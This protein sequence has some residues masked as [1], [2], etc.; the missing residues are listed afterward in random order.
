MTEFH[1]IAENHLSK[2]VLVLVF[3]DNREFDEAHMIDELKSLVEAAG[4]QVAGVITQNKKSV[5]A[6]T[7]IGSGKVDEVRALVEAEGAELVVF[8]DELS[9]SQMRNLEER[10]GV[11]VMD[12]TALILDIFAGRAETQI[13]KLQI[14]LARQKYRLPR[15]IGFGTEMSRTGSRGGN[16]VGGTRG[17]GEQKLELDRRAVQRRI[18]ELERQIEEANRSRETQRGRRE[19]S[20]IPI[21]A[22]V[23]YT[24]AGKSS[25]MNCMIDCSTEGIDDKKVFE[26]NMLFATLDTFH[27]K[28]S[29]EDK[30]QVIFTDTVGFVSKLPHSLVSAFQSTLEE[31]TRADLLVQVVD[32]AHLDYRFQMSVTEE[33]LSVIGAGS[34]P[35]ITAFNK[36]DLIEHRPR[37]DDQ[38]VCI[39]TKTGEGIDELIERIKAALFDDRVA[40]TFLIPFDQGAI[41]SYLQ[42]EYEGT[43]EYTAEGTLI[44]AEVRVAD[45]GRYRSYVRN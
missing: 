36:V 26:R 23:G 22:L 37:L 43:V 3:Q 31:A 13:A 9:G 5:E 32:A 35:M 42:S 1:T 19:K 39:S 2:A 38:S 33:V 8:N 14:E 18:Q 11:T 34:I 44:H 28:V 17:A 10:I 45:Y 6:A 12:R 30:K 16:M 21:V 20:E 27:R 40:A 15:L 29:F 7:Y 41:S 4:V 25:L 24:N